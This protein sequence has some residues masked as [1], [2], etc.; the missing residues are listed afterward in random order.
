DIGRGAGLAVDLHAS[1]LHRGED[2]RPP[3]REV[4]S[5]VEHLCRGKRRLSSHAHRR[6]A[7]SS[8]ILLRRYKAELTGAE[9]FWLGLVRRVG[10]L[11]LVDVV[12]AVT[13]VR[14]V[15]LGRGAVVAGL[16]LELL[17]VELILALG[18]GL[19]GPAVPLRRA[20]LRAALALAATATAAG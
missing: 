8:S 18:L 1:Q 15:E 3:L 10:G 6:H 13:V 14:V 16:G 19:R 4:V 20:A 17:D 9:R 11:A 5:G 2:V 7:S 12:G